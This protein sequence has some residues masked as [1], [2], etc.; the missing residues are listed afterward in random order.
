MRREQRVEFVVAV[1]ALFTLGARRVLLVI[2]IPELRLVLIIHLR[3][4]ETGRAHRILCRPRDG[5]AIHGRRKTE[6]FRHIGVFIP[7]FHILH[8]L[9]EQRLRL[10]ARARSPGQRFQSFTSRRHARCGA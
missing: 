1:G 4:L 7:G 9:I 2:C 5:R 10:L 8:H 6:R 3:Q